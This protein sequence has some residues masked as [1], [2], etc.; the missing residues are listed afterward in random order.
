MSNTVRTRRARILG[1]AGAVLLLAGVLAIVIAVHAQKSAPQPPANA[2][3]PVNVIPSRNPSGH[4]RTPASHSPGP[5]TRG[6][7]LPRSVPLRLRIP[8]IGVDSSLRKIGL[9]R[10]GHIV[11]PPLVRDSHAY[12]LTVSPTPGQ[13]GPATIIGHVDSAAYGPGV[14]FKLG[15]LRQ[16][17]KIY[18]TRVDG[19]VALFEVEKVA[20]YSKATFPTQKV[21]GNID[22]AGL[23]L[24]TCGGTF[25]RAI[26]SYGSNIVVYAALV[27]AHHA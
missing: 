20:E 1:V 26:G 12:W 24:I 5:T 11:T 22:H 27:S 15:A 18:L 21:Y 9:N 4:E 6:L 13:L 16:R 17:D 8:A 23:R 7:I 10:Q 2:A 25:N 19:T 14:F 3:S